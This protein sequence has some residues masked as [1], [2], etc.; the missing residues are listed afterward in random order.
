MIEVYTDNSSIYHWFVAVILPFSAFLKMLF[1]WK[2]IKVL[3]CWN[4]RE[5]AR[6]FSLGWKG[7][8]TPLLNTAI[9]K[10]AMTGLFSPTVR[11]WTF[12]AVAYRGN[13]W[14]KVMK[15]LI[16]SWYRDVDAVA[17]SWTHVEPADTKYFA[18]CHFCFE[19]M[20]RHCFLLL[21]EC[22][23]DSRYHN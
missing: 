18:I 13:P 23:K 4:K 16:D 7:P 20:H 8:L 6:S 2:G 22:F 19:F 9:C 5:W 10:Y 11:K 12:A 3:F 1:G 15:A 14:W 17:G 21:L